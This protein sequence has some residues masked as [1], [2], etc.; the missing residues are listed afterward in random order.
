MSITEQPV[1]F[2]SGGFFDDV[3]F[4]QII[5]LVLLIPGILITEWTRPI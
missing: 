1:A 2:I 4:Q 5:Q 3:E